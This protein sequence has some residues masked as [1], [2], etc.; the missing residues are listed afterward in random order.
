MKFVKGMIIGGAICGGIA[1]LYADGMYMN[2]KRLVKKGR[3]VLKKI[4]VVR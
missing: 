3:Q 2:R 4:G 1:V